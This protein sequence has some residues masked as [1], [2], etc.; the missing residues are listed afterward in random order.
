MAGDQ[1]TRRRP[2]L[3]RR[4]VAE[5]VGTALLTAAVV[6]S[7]IMGERLAGGNVAVALLANTAATAGALVALILLILALGDLSGAQFNPLVSVADALS[8]R[9]TAT[10]AASYVTAQL[11]GAIAGAARADAM[12]GL[13]TLALSTHSR[14][15]GAIFFSE[16]VATFGL[17]V[18]IRGTSRRQPGR[19]PFAVAAYITAA[20]WFTSSTSFANPAVTVARSLTDTFAGIQPANVP[21]FLV[22]QVLGAVSAVALTAWWE[23]EPR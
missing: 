9:L 22:A 7:G 12:F 2:S 20:Y 19:T 15:G 18:V 5:G 21:A 14:A 1:A 11:C 3:T 23:R 16:V 10:E 8:G 4:A 17:L 13:P 6:G